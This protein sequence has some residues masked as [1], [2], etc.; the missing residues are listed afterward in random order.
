MKLI[1]RIFS[2]MLLSSITIAA[3][4]AGYNQSAIGT[5]LNKILAQYTSQQLVNGNTQMPRGSGLPFYAFGDDRMIRTAS[6]WILE[7]P[8]TSSTGKNYLSQ[9]VTQQKE[10]AQA[11]AQQN[12]IINSNNRKFAVY[13]D[14][15]LRIVTGPVNTPAI[16]Q[17][18]NNTPINFSSLRGKTIEQQL[19]FIMNAAIQ[20]TKSGQTSNNGSDIYRLPGSLDRIIRLGNNQGW[21]IESYNQPNTIWKAFNQYNST[22]IKQVKLNDQT[23]TYQGYDFIVFIDGPVD[24]SN[25]EVLRI[26]IRG[27][28]QK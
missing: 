26:F 8:V 16:N 9:S 4:N 18:P 3:V 12:Q 21:M 22:F 13:T 25:N 20:A 6:G 27:A 5:Y 24:G 15:I 7:S 2:V 23:R 28:N 1:N 10:L 14:S 19:M 17:Q 11:I